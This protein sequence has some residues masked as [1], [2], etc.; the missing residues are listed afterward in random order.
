[1]PRYECQ[2]RTANGETRSIFLDAASHDALCDR[3]S[4]E[5]NTLETF[6]EVTGP[7]VGE[8]VALLRS[9]A[10]DVTRHVA[11]LA[12]AGMPLESG[13]RA[14]ADDLAEGKGLL[15]LRR[16]I[17][18]RRNALLHIARRLESGDT[19]DSILASQRAPAD[20]HAAIRGGM[21]T[22]HVAEAVGE[23]LVHAN[24]SH[25]SRRRAVIW[26][27]YPLFMGAFL[28]AILSVCLLWLVPLFKQLFVDFGIEL[29]LITRVLIGLSDGFARMIRLLLTPAG[30][31]VFAAVL[32]VSI[33]GLR[34]FA[35]TTSGGDFLR[36]VPILGSI[37]HWNAMSRFGHL[38]AVL[39]RH[40]MALP[41]ALRVAAKGT[42]DG[43][44]ERQCGAV[45]DDIESGV[46]V[47]TASGAGLPVGFLQ[48]MAANS[49]EP[50]D[51]FPDAL[52]SL[53]DL[54]DSRT[55]MRAWF[56]AAVSE[57]ILLVLLVGFPVG[58]VTLALFLPLIQL[59]NNLA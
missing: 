54:Y 51:T 2:I 1:M 22:G 53:A 20:L 5:G 19:I 3:V 48:L 40:G 11:E 34:R 57:P 25:S 35:T 52:H 9:E 37:V 28:L 14:I 18:R 12:V 27:A 58:Y 10:L 29:P 7:D 6:V 31:S 43:V 26:L 59:L 4:A 36:F 32:G 55:R 47:S 50:S 15:P 24:Q 16:S 44:I 41:D 30:L 13:L 45:A 42:R 38:F 39:I 56:V 17:Q 46:P 21:Q 8:E 33:F 23:Y 49:E